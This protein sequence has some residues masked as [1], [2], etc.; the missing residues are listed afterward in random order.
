[1]LVLH[2]PNMRAARITALNALQGPLARAAYNSRVAAAL[3]T[4]AGAHQETRESVAACPNRLPTRPQNL[5][6][7]AGQQRGTAEV[8]CET[9]SF[10]RSSMQ[11]SPK[12]QRM[13]LCNMMFPR[14]HSKPPDPRALTPALPHKVARYPHHHPPPVV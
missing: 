7:F 2:F 1:M 11:D 10:S 4:Q 6:F 5:G 3:L 12:K 13:L 8:P 14:R 9:A